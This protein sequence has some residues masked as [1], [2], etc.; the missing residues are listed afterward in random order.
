M[1]TVLKVLPLAAAFLL[2]ALASHLLVT[3]VERYARLAILW[4]WLPLALAGVLMAWR[5][6]LRWIVLAA[7]VGATLGIWHWTASVTIDPGLIFMIQYLAIQTGLAGFFG[8]TLRRGHQPL[9]TRLARAVHGHLPPEIERYTRS[10]TLVW[11]LFFV[12]LG[13]VASLLYVAASTQ[14]WSVWVNF[15]TPLAIGAM[16]GVEYIVRRRSF[17]NFE[18]V[19]F[20]TAF[21]A[22]QND[23]DQRKA[24]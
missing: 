14:W 1:S 5:T 2:Y 8:S 10:V 7:L 18:H 22:F 3:Q 16:F 17:P 11:T 23:L 9:V 13:V 12:M 4:I 24:D 6:A 20:M 15:L 19:T 21:R